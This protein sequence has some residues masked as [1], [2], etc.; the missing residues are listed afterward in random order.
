MATEIKTWEI[1]EDRLSE[2]NTTLIDSGRKEKE[3]LEKWLKTE[4]EILGSDIK[5]IGEQVY[6]LSGP[7]DYLGIDK[8]GN[9]VIIE[10][11]RDRLPREAL[12]QAIDYASDISSWERDKI[13]EI[14][15]N[16]TS[17]SLD[18]FITESFE[19]IDI[20]NF[21]INDSQ[22]LL[23]VGFSIDSALSRM[24]EWLS[25]KYDLVINAILLKYI[26]TS[27]GNELLSRT[28]IIPEDVE[29]AKIDKKK[30]KIEMS[31]EPGVYEEYELKELLF[32]YLQRNLWSS[33]RMKII[34]IPYL[35]KTQKTVSRE[36]LKQEFL[37]NGGELGG[38]DSKQA[39]I[40]ISLISNQLGQ[41]K[42]D[43][44]RQIIMYDYPTYH[45]EKDN[46]KI[47][48]EYFE[49]VKEVMLSIK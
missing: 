33:R 46:F 11:K 44:L 10:L 8:K 41:K 13:N 1:V 18:D 34:M 3:H 45:W 37:K 4:S 20:D 28:A 7:L 39:G 49:L 42:N 6:T 23:L 12:A 9:L 2:I 25:D 19:N 31:D 14:C 38:I 40:Y 47:N 16:Y 29:N 15:F 43:F 21:S 35:L 22:R 27:S 32:Q 24:I 5:I 26:R 30:N 36:E 48:P 17:Q